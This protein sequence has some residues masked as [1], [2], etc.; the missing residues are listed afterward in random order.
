MMALFSDKKQRLY[1][2]IKP[3]TQQGVF[4]AVRK[5]KYR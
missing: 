4:H 3:T 2:L 1:Y 5:S